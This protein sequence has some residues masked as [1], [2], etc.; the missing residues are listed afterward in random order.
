MP[1]VEQVLLPTSQVAERLGVHV[2][3]V[4]RMVD[5]GEIK[6]AAK[7]PGLRGPLLFTEDEVSRVEQDGA[8]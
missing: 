1:K 5:R 8:A 4:H 7:V 2:R 3:T 6:A